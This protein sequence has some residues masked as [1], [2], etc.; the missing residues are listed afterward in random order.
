MENDVDHQYTFSH[1]LKG[2]VELSLFDKYFLKVRERK[3]KRERS[4]KLELA[5]LNP[6]PRHIQ[7]MAIHWLAAAIVA[8]LAGLAFLYYL[9]SGAGSDDLWGTLAAVA[10]A[11][12]LS[13][14]F[15]T[16]FL[17]TSERK[18]V[19]ETRASLYPLVEIPYRKKEHAQAKQFIEQL[20]AAIERNVEAKGYS[21]D[22]LFAG[23]MRMLRRLAKHKVLSI[24]TYDKAK[25]HMLEGGKQA[26][27]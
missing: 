25:K 12:L 2:E 22:A 9:F 4:F 3:L 1:R 14:V 15:T 23:E 27:A 13:A 21:A 20:Q 6:E 7:D 11:A 18:W 5:I 17:Y 10:V 8:G 19:F 26:A 24:D 16:L